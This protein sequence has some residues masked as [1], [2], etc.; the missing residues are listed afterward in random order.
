MVMSLGQLWLYSPLWLRS[1]S[2]GYLQGLRHSWSGDRE[3][4][5]SSSKVPLLKLKAI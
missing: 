2:K 1:A 3:H 5:A 4:Q